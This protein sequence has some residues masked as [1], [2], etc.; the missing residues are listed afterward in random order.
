[1]CAVVGFTTILPLS[2]LWYSWTP[3]ENTIKS[4]ESRFCTA[5]EN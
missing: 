2:F 3:A 4:E 5:S 1:M